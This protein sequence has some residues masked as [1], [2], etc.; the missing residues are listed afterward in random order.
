MIVT[1]DHLN[2]FIVQATEAKLFVRW[3]DGFRLISSLSPLVNKLFRGI[4]IWLKSQIVLACTQMTEYQKTH[5]YLADNW[6]LVYSKFILR[7]LR[8]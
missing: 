1:Y 6:C 2:I 5:I 4:L 3:L 7:R 8:I